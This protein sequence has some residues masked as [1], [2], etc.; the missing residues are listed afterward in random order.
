MAGVLAHR[1]TRAEWGDVVVSWTA[2]H[3]QPFLDGSLVGLEPLGPAHLAGY[4]QMLSEPEVLRMTGSRALVGL[5]PAETERRIAEWLATRVDHADRAD[6]AI[7]RAAD[8]DFVG[9]IVLFQL[10]AP[11]AAVTLR[12]ALAGPRVFDRGYGTEAIRLA[13]DYAFDVVGLHRVGLDV[14]DFNHRAQR[15]YAKCGFVIEGR[16]RDTLW[17]DGE[18]HDSILM[19]VVATDPRG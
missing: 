12:I 2:F 19:S 10:D 13:L 18:W 6:W 17:W 15:A 14:F 4:R 16:Q 11:N 5:G 1:E 7:V 9:E 8:N 3:D